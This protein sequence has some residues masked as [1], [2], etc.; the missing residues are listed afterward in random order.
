[1]LKAWFDRVVWK[2]GLIAHRNPVDLQV[3]CT[4]T[5]CP[6]PKCNVVSDDIWQ[7]QSCLFIMYGKKTP[8]SISIIWALLKKCMLDPISLTSSCQVKGSELKQNP[9]EKL[10]DGVSLH[11]NAWG[12]LIFPSCQGYSATPNPF[13]SPPISFQPGECCRS[14]SSHL[15]VSGFVPSKHSD[16]KGKEGEAGGSGRKRVRAQASNG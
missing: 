12:V 7:L 3:A 11:A 1:M 9:S 4:F 8:N 13:Q 2:R 14:P 5:I 10:L 16:R 15:P 6:N